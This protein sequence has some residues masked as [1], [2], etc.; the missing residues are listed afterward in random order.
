MASEHVSAQT[1]LG[2]MVTSTDDLETLPDAGRSGRAPQTYDILCQ[3]CFSTRAME[4]GKAMLRQSSCSI[5]R[6]GSS[7]A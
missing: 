7:T 5:Y 2:D 3:S 4:V 1:P 6:K